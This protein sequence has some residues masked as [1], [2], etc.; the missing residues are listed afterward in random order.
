MLVSGA[1]SRVGV[2]HLAR[3]LLGR[4]VLSCAAILR[5]FLRL[6]VTFLCRFASFYSGF[7]GGMEFATYFVPNRSYK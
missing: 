5:L 4:L 7:G 2:C 3:V 6:E 1:V